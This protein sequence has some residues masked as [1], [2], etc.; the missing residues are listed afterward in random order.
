MVPMPTDDLAEAIAMLRQK[1]AAHMEQVQRIDA[2]LAAL[3]DV[4]E[5][6]GRGHEA[7][8]GLQRT[9]GGL[10]TRQKLVALLD[11]GDR[12]WSVRE[13][14]DEYENRGDPFT[15]SNPDSAIRA[16]IVTAVEKDEIFR[17]DV[18]RYK[19]TKFRLT[20]HD[21]GSNGHAPQ[22]EA[23]FPAQQD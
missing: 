4:I 19:S 20:S 2:A 6:P 12:D 3:T 11:E 22:E 7:P 15:G 21:P 16:A 18:G 1:R 14:I 5:K 17:Q 13:V 23:P 10:T 9:A 8:Q